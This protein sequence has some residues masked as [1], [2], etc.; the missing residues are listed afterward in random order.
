MKKTLQ[1]TGIIVAVLLLAM[2]ILPFAFKGKVSGIVQKQAEKY[3]MAKLSFNDLSLNL[4]SNF[5]NITASLNDFTI[6]GVDSFAK[7]TLVYA[8]K[9]RLSIDLN[10]L[11]SENGFKIKKVELDHSRVLAKM[12]SD[13]SANWDIMKPDTAISAEKETDTAAMHFELEKVVLD[14]AYVVYDDRKHDMLAVLTGWNGTLDGDL[15]TDVTTLTTQSTVKSLSYT[16]WGMPILRNAHFETELTMEAD[17]NKYKFT[18]T[19]TKILLNAMEIAFGGSVALPDSSHI[20]FDLKANIE[21]GTFKQLLSLV[22]ALYA[23]DFESIK[24][25]GNLQLDFFM[26]GRMTDVNYPAFCLKLLVDNAMFRYPALPE[27]VKDINIHLNISNPGGSLDKTLVDLSKFHFNMAGNPFDLTAYVSTP[28]SDPEVKGT[29]AGV[30]NLGVV[31]DIYPLA[32]GTRL[33]GQIEANLSAAGRMSYLDKKQYDRFK[34]KGTLTVKDIHYVSAGMPDIS[35]KLAKMNFTPQNV[36][37]SAFS[38]MVGKNDIQ[39]SGKLDNMLGWLL[40]DEVLSGSLNITSSYLNINDFMTKDSTVPSS[41]DTFPLVAF[42]IPRNWNFNLNASGKKVLFSSLTLENVL[43]TM[44]VKDGRV[45]IKNMS[46]NALGGSVGMNGFYEALHPDKPKVAFG[47]DLQNVSFAQTFTTFD[48]VKKLAPIFESIQGNYSMKLD[49]NSSLNKY[50]EPD[51][52]SLTGKGLMKSSGV[53]V[54]DVKVLDVLATTLKKESLRTIAPKDLTIPFKI[55]EGNVTTSPFTVK[56]GDLSLELSG[57]T[58]L[59]KTIKYNMSVNL[60]EKAAVAGITSMKGTITGTFSKP[61]I[62]LNT[63]SIARQVA[64]NIADELLSKTI[65]TNTAETVGK[66]KEELNKQAELM[67]AQAQ[68]A[69]DK[70]IAQAETEGNNLVAQAK[71]PILKAAAKAAAAKLKTEAEKKAADLMVKTEKEIKEIAAKAQP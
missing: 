14:N 39:A 32:K 15:S 22:P 60:P 36:A 63:A 7:D 24:T 20:D 65:G 31:K 47:M 69:G 2:I 46:A 51:L 70:L 27:S 68:V 35:V 38:M 3:L 64:T 25:A 71:N 33:K 48:F 52:T 67:R 30:I 6:L 28:M 17:L 16:L 26:K 5:P 43:A 18:F 37:L 53:K 66:A 42:E 21:K 19:T 50:M 34:A 9:A 29:A 11:I 12:L 45:T 23:K 49:F 62:N 54:S 1:I 55:S 8:E 4:F 58:G 40:R 57:I 13:G 10:S 56:V 59:D 41:S 44:T 61:K